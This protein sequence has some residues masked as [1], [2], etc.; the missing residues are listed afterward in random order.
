MITKSKYKYIVQA[1]MREVRG[2]PIDISQFSLQELRDA[3]AW[4]GPRDQE[5][6]YR[7]LM[8]NE[9]KKRERDEERRHQSKVRASTYFIRVLIGLLLIFVGILAE[10]YLIS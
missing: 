8:R 1:F 6:T 10:R 2:D 3:D 5:S 9:I 4:A 7:I